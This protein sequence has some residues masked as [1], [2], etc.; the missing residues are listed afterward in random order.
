MLTRVAKKIIEDFYGL[1]KL[2]YDEEKRDRAEKDLFQNGKNS[3]FSYFF[4][5]RT[6]S[7]V[8]LPEKLDL[9]F[10]IS[11]LRNESVQDICCIKIPEEI[12]YA[13]Y[14]IIGTCLSVKHL[15]SVFKIVNKK[16]KQARDEEEMHSAY[17]K[18]KAGKES[19]WCAIEIGQV[20]IHL[21]LDEYRSYYDLESLWSC[22]IE[23][24]DKYQ[25]FFKKFSEFEQKL[26]VDE[27]EPSQNS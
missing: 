26:L 1:D 15:N 24:D 16:Y 27:K 2:E 10:L 14:M 3:F 5:Y 21:F 7:M 23:F 20:V 25:K 9:D 11:L 6:Y 19:K 8:V 4:L 17:L 13:D 12:N 22:G 18:R